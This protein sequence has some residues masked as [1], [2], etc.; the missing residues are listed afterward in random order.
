MFLLILPVVFMY[1]SL[2]YPI[3][4]YELS[5]NKMYIDANLYSNQVLLRQSK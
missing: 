5:N 2:V 1:L 4:S 3:R